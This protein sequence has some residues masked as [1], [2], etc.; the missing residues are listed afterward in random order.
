MVLIGHGVGGV[1]GGHAAAEPAGL[2]IQEKPVVAAPVPPTPDADPDAHMKIEGYATGTMAAA[3]GGG[4]GADG[5]AGGGGGGGDGDGEDGADS[6]WQDIAM[7]GNGGGVLACTDPVD[8]LATAAAYQG[9]VAT[10]HHA[11]PR[12][13]FAILLSPFYLFIDVSCLAR[14]R[15][16]STSTIDGGACASTTCCWRPGGSLLCSPA[17]EHTATAFDFCPATDGL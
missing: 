13:T 5:G 14:S 4:A 11:T 17:A 10:P 12:H 6:E 8:A 3:G 2:P 7:H 16:T 1:V 15:P 9:W